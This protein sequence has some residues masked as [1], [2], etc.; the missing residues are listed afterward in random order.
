MT[1]N[2]GKMMN[3]LD[4]EKCLDEIL[5]AVTPEDEEIFFIAP[6]YLKDYT[7]VVIGPIHEDW[8]GNIANVF[9]T[10]NYCDLDDTLT[11]G[12]FEEAKRKLE[13]QDNSSS[14]CFKLKEGLKIAF[15]HE[16][17]LSD[18]YP[19]TITEPKWFSLYNEWTDLKNE[20]KRKHM[21]KEELAASAKFFADIA[22]GFE[23]A[24]KKYTL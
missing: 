19:D 10:K 3:Y 4:G 11:W 17:F 16:M 1:E 12:A 24:M 7:G 20:Y 21:S 15:E 6:E 22:S 14:K 18:C 2:G 5:A 8:Y 9:L 13:E 23:N